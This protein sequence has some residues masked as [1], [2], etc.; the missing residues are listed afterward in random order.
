MGSFYGKNVNTES[1]ELFNSHVLNGQVHVV[2][3][4]RQRWNNKITVI[5]DDIHDTLI[6]SKAV[7]DEEED[8]G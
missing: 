7:Y 4:Q 3:S 6:F 8:D 5:Y 2:E 1:E